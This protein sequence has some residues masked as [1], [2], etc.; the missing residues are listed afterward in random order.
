MDQRD[1]AAAARLLADAFRNGQPIERL[2]GSLAPLDIADAY[3][4]Q[5][6]VAR[7]RGPITGWKIANGN[8][9]NC[10]PVFTTLTPRAG[11]ALGK[12]RQPKAE[13]E[14]G[15]VVLEDMPLRDHP[16]RAEEVFDRIAVAPV[17]E[18]VASRYQDRTKCTRFE[19]LA[20]GSNGALIAGDT[21]RKN[22]RDLD[23]RQIPVTLAVNGTIVQSALGTHPLP[24]PA[25]LV[26]WLANHAMQRTGLKRGM[27][28]T[29][30]GLKGATPVG[31][32]DRLTGDW[33]PLG[34]MDL[35]CG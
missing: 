1:I 8:P 33:G 32:G 2:S 27:V 18:I 23:F 15:F 17:I 12:L 4:I 3:A 31:S 28:A 5:D 30:G 13:V 25:T 22:W 9:P 10:S 29:T 20:D 24:N 26:T 16:Y 35:V 34:S 14:F 11:V 7:L 21:V 6:E 19:I